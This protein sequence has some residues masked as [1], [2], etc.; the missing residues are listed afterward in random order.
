M[1]P[2]KVCPSH[3]HSAVQ[4]EVAKLPINDAIGGFMLAGLSKAISSSKTE[5]LIIFPPQLVP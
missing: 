3:S 2:K 5:K 1:Q 4:F